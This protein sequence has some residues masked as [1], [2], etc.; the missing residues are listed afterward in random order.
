MMTTIRRMAIPLLGLA[1]LAAAADQPAPRFDAAR[2]KTGSFTYRDTVDGKPGSLSTSTIA[3]LPD[4]HYR[5]TADFPA[6]DQSWSTVATRA[7]GPVETTLKMRTRDGR[8]Y[9]MTLKYA[10]PHVSGEAITSESVDGRLP[11]ADQSVAGDISADTVDQR[12]DWAT[13]MTTDKKPGESFE[14]EVYDAKTASSRVSCAVS[15]AG[16]M[17]TPLGAVHAIKLQYT[18]Y[19]ASG[20]EVYTVYTSEVFPR[21]ML[22]EDL[23]GGL[24]TLLVKAD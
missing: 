21:A 1:A 13:V 18:V 2:L 8:H 9:L 12:I 10:G 15:D 5:F 17:D 7:M 24:T 11:G 4:G 16:M 6:F 19:K 3:L 20:T 23:P 14:F 22:R